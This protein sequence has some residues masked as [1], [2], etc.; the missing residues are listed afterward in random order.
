MRYLRACESEKTQTNAIDK[1]ICKPRWLSANEFVVD[2]WW[3]EGR[4]FASKCEIRWWESQ[5]LKWKQTTK[6]YTKKTSNTIFVLNGLAGWQ[7]GLVWPIG[8]PNRLAVRWVDVISWN[9]C[10]NPFF[11][12]GLTN[13]PFLPSLLTR[14][15]IHEA[16]IITLAMVV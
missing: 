11:L 16:S 1:V 12:N 5:Q 3:W 13:W 14:P 15:L 9:L 10:P 8:W 2:M 6:H 7:V 4:D